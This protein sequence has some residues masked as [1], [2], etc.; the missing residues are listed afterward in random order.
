M[1]LFSRATSEVNRAMA[2]NHDAAMYGFAAVGFFFSRLEHYESLAFPFL[3]RAGTRFVEFQSLKW[4]E[5]FAYLFPIASDAVVKRIYDKLLKI[6]QDVRDEV[7][8][9]FGGEEG[10]LV[11]VGC[12]LAP[13]SYDRLRAVHYTKSSFQD[14]EILTNAFSA[15]DELDGWIRSRSPYVEIEKFAMTGLPVPLYGDRLDAIV[16]AIHN[17]GTFDKWIERELQLLDLYENM[18]L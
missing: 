12:G 15:F 14:P 13:P 2:A 17:P 10:V 7:F 6:K 9:G 8:H 16:A 1:N 3:H 4:R 5:R 11:D 18:D